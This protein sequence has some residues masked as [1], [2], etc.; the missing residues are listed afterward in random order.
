M[1]GKA[2]IYGPFFRFCRSLVCLFYP[3]FRVL[4]EENIKD[5][6]V[7]LLPHQNLFGPF[8]MLLSFP[9]EV[10]TWMLDVFLDQKTCFRQYRD[11]TFTKRFGMPKFVAAVIAYGASL[12]I[13]KLMRSGGGV[14][15]YRGSKNIVK[16]MKESVELL[17]EKQSIVL[18]PNKDYTN[19]ADDMSNLYEG[20]LFLEKYFYKETGLSK[21][22]IKTERMEKTMSFSIRS[23]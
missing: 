19:T 20:F 12:I 5:G 7:Y 22:S 1:R 10:R 11:Y 8:I 6:A 3:P 23:V 2:R 14:A 9:K 17:K 13:P 15:V 18:F 4:K 21:K 16:T